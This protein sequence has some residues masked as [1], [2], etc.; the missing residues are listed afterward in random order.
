VGSNLQQRQATW[1][2]SSMSINYC[3]SGVKWITGVHFIYW[4]KIWSTVVPQQ[5][6]KHSQLCRTVTMVYQIWN[7]LRY[8][9]RPSSHV[10]NENKGTGQNQSYTW[11]TVLHVLKNEATTVLQNLANTNPIIKCHK[12]NNASILLLELP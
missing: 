4:S 2:T 10:K 1:F 3:G 12:P 6:T 8:G 7:H 11:L 9:L 5:N